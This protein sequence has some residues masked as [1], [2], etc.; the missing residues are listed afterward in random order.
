[1]FGYESEQH[2]GIFRMRQPTLL[3]PSDFDLS[4]FFE[5][6]KFNAIA[7][8]GFDY[9]QIQWA[10]DLEAKEELAAAQ[11]RSSQTPAA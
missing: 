9:Q 8:G 4:P 11:P 3:T 7:G 1:M 10:R 6:V 2:T 5:V